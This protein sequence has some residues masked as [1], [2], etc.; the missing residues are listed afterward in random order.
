[1][2]KSAEY[3]LE[4]I[5]RRQAGQTDPNDTTSTSGVVTSGSGTTTLS[6]MSNA[7]TDRT[8]ATSVLPTQNIDAAGN[9]L[10]M[11]N[12]NTARTTTTKVLPTQ[13]I[14][15][16]GF[17]RF[18]PYHPTIP[19]LSRSGVV[20]ADLLAGPGTVTCTKLTGVGAM[21]AGAYYLAVVAGNQ[22]G[23]SL[24]QAGNTTVTTETTNLG[25]RLAFAQVTGATFYD[26]YATTVAATWV[27]RVTEAQRA[28][29]IIINGVGTTTAGGTAGA[30]DCYAIGTGLGAAA[31]TQSTFWNLPAYNAISGV[32]DTSGY[33]Y[34]DFDGVCSRSGDSVAPSIAVCPFFWNATA[35]AWEPGSPYTP[36]F[37]GASGAY[38]PMTFSARAECRGRLTT[39]VVQAIAGTG[40]S[41]TGYVT[42]S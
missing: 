41:L 5:W 17:P 35:A 14:D 4:R 29:G 8:T 24:P 36:T 19:V 18:S 22:Y 3:W 13:D 33:Q 30:V 31:I 38:G 21:T 23:R 11:T 40:M 16:L 37:G 9:V 2:P 39:W 12:A 7:N 34:C 20:A 6:G 26:I 28:S 10:G 25:V 1:M 27:G 15:P 32:H 42:L